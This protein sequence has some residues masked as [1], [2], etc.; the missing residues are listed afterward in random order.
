MNKISHL[1]GISAVSLLTLTG[2]MDND[3]DLSNIDTTSELKLV[4]LTLPLNFDNVTLKEVIKLEDD[5]KVKVVNVGGKEVYAVTENGSF[6]SDEVIAHGFHAKGIA[7]SPIQARFGINGASS[8]RRRAHRA[9]SEL[10]FELQQGGKQDLAFRAENVDGSI[11]G[12]TTI[13]M[14]KDPSRLHF[15][16]TFST[17]ATGLNFELHNVVL[18]LPQGLIIDNL[19]EGMTYDSETGHLN[20]QKIAVAGVKSEINLSVTGIDVSDV[21]SEYANHVLTYNC[22]VGIDKAT[23]VVSGSQTASLGTHIDMTAH[24][25]FDD[26]YID[27]FSGNIEYSLEGQGLDISPIYLSDLPDILSQ[28]ETDL[29]LANPQLYVKFNNPLSELHLAFQSNFLLTSNRPEGSKSFT[30]DNNV[31]IILGY[32]KGDGPYSYVLSPKKP[33]QDAAGYANA[34]HVPFSDLSDVLSGKGLPSSI[35]VKLVDPCM[36][37]QHVDHFLLDHSYGTVKGTWEFLAPLALKEGSTIIYRD[38]LDGWGSEDLDKLDISKLTISAMVANHAPLN[39]QLTMKPIDYQGNVIP[40]LEVSPVTLPSGT[41]AQPITI[42]VTGDLH[43]FDGIRLEA[44]VHSASSD[45][46]APDQTITLSDVKAT[47][48][49]KYVTDF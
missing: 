13:F 21:K 43:N 20:I 30:T 14:R 16:I 5:S 6:E 46:L 7:T 18:T 35:D 27:A 24:A 8:A 25:S 28:D 22:P 32:D 26:F 23:L 36:K 40:G 29:K 3:Y 34:T 37:R 47:V 11:T 48:S 42:T 9:D 44:T 2:C 4:D 10:K 19:S 45:A 38:V 15:D 31:P 33:A 12:I 49:G 39:A 1:L 17:D 41:E